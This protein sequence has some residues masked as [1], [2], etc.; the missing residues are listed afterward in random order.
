M[1]VVWKRALVASMMTASVCGFAQRRAAAPALPLKQEARP[2]AELRQCGVGLTS[3]QLIQF[4][5][6]GVPDTSALPEEPQEKSQLII[7]AMAKLASLKAEDAVP[8]L[9]KIA[10]VEMPQ[11]VMQMLDYDVR[12][13]SPEG[14]E[15]FRNRALRLMQYNA[16]NAL[17]LIGKTSSR[18][19]VRSIFKQET[20]TNARI[21][22]AVCLASLGDASGV[23]FLVDVIGR[24]NRRQSAAAARAFL[25]ITGQD[26]GY[27]EH[28]PVRARRSRAATYAQWW[29]ANRGDYIVDVAAVNERRAAPPIN[30]T[31]QPRNTR[32]LLKLASNYFDFNN[33]TKSQ[34]ARKALK[35]AGDS[36]NGDLE[37]IAQDVNEDLNIR[38]EAMNWYYEANR[39]NTSKPKALMKRL[40]RD[41]NPE[42]SDKANTLLEQI[43]DDEKP[44]VPPGRR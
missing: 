2:A 1:T 32:D 28:T 43:E 40:K 3:P 18:A 22:Y 24:E 16:V 8:T 7:D 27:T 14:R 21:Q 25:I 29:R 44:I 31:Y 5:E 23:D 37:R 17:S 10:S 19:L 13:T 20:D 12:N 42:I 11:G 15:D 9:E 34:D 36:I 38:M 30:M 33:M 35:D 6:A 4:L 26:F 39:Q 41:E